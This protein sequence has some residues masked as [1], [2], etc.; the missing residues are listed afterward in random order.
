VG[1]WEKKRSECR[2][3]EGAVAVA[4]EGCCSEGG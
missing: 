2:R 1:M 4:V 3:E